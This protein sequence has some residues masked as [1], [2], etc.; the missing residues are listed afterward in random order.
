MDGPIVGV[1]GIIIMFATLF[2]FRIPAAFVMAIIGF[3]GV[4]YVTSFKNSCRYY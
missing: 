3:L 4:A 2:L 1:Y